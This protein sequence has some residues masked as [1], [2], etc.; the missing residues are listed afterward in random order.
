MIEFE[1]DEDEI[2]EIDFTP[3]QFAKQKEKKKKS[4]T[5]YSSTTTSVT[6]AGKKTGFDRVYDQ[7]MKEHMNHVD[8]NLMKTNP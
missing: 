7:K 4:T 6:A 3:N 2:A 8:K 5:P 1:D